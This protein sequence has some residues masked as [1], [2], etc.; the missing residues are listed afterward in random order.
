MLN[1]LFPY[2]PWY[3]PIYTKDW[4]IS[5]GKCWYINIPMI[6]VDRSEQQ[7][8]FR[9]RFDISAAI[10]SLPSLLTCCGDVTRFCPRVVNIIYHSFWLVC[11]LSICFGVRKVQLNQLDVKFKW[12]FEYKLERC[13]T[14]QV[15]AGSKVVTSR[16]QSHP[17]PARC[18]STAAMV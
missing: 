7:T 11:F 2:A 13:S 4:V 8:T 3:W 12:V 1:F 16:E 5:V 10:V 15:R 18:R 14:D 6:D 9:D 17:I